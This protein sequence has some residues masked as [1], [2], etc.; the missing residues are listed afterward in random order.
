MSFRS[1]DLLR[2]LDDF[3]RDLTLIY[4]SEGTYDPVT[5]SLTGGSTSNATVRGYFYNYR[6]DEVDGSSIVLGD[7]RLL[8]PNIDTSGDPLTEP[9]IGDEVT[10]S[11]D[12][13]S[14]VSVTKIFSG[15]ALICYLCQVR[16]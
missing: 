6:L 4:V 11:G 14:I 3:G 5:S 13:V 15:T 7:R 12:K 10:G 16:E 8:L 9:D 2:M 1:Y